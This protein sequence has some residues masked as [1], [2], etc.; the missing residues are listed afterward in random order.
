MSDCGCSAGEAKTKAEQRVLRVALGLNATMFVVGMAGGLVA[1]SSGLIADSLDMLADA[2][3]YAIAL[4]AVTRGDVFKARA[5]GLS[6]VLLLVLGLAVLG[7]A[8]RRALMG[9]A[10]EGA[11][12]IAVACLSLIVNTVVLGM[13]GK[14][15]DGGVHLNA[16]WIFTRVDVVANI[17][18]VI[19]GIAVLWSGIRFIDL[20]VGAA[21]GLYVIK[22]ALEILGQ[23]RSARRTAEA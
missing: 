7:D 11:I 4:T 9:N 12:M 1:R 18:V 17:A 13:L 15:R 2:T 6:G 16:S 19:S 21:I 8:G 20:V 23:A 22:E 10:P 5:A 3:A 14:V